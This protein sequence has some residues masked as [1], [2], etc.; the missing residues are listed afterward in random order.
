M[1]R[2][3]E[4]AA[5]TCY[6]TECKIGDDIAETRAF[7]RKIAQVKK[8]ESVI[9]HANVTVRFIC[10]RGVTHE[11]VR[12]RLAAYS[13]ESTRYCNY[14]K[15]QFDNEITVIRPPFW[16]SDSPAYQAWERSCATAERE[17]LELLAQ[18]RSPQEARSVLPN[19][20]KTEI[21]M[22]ANLREWK[23]VFR[24]RCASSAH[25]QMRQLMV[26]LFVEFRSCMPEIYDDINTLARFDAAPLAGVN[27]P[28]R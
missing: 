10:D 3:I 28:R 19:S 24:M 18:G 26:P 13:Q 6:K 16:P 15:D 4:R 25:P 2:L 1:Y 5:R 8:H 9:E 7:V 17:Y 22:T 14:G 20:L 23:H 21:W 27:G 11:L 12:H